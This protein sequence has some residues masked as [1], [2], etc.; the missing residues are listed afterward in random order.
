MS[1]IPAAAAQTVPQ[2]RST[3]LH[4]DLELLLAFY[5][6]QRA[7]LP[8][9][10]AHAEGVIPNPGFFT[11]ASLQRLLNN[12]LLNPD[13]I[14][15]IARAQPVPLQSACYYKIIQQK[16][17]FFMDKSVIEEHLRG[18]A[19]V[20]LEGLDILDA[21]INAF[22][23]Q[24]DAGLPCSL[25]N[26]VAFFSQA[27]NEAYRGHLDVDDVLVIHLSGEK[28]WRLFDAQAPRRFDMSELTPVQMGRQIADLVMKPGDALYVRA[29]VP[30]ICDTV[31]S[32]SL[33]LAFDLCD[34]TPQ[35]DLMLQIATEQ[36]FHACAASYTPA[37]DVLDKFATKLLSP[38]FK[39]EMSKRTESMRAEAAT[40]RTA[41]IG[42]ASRVSA[43]DRFI[44][45]SED[46]DK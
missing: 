16:K 4:P 14:G 19:S 37:P 39:G 26:S 1:A 27:G 22:A 43:L 36:Y 28:R 40:F 20:V 18:G 21:G 5:R 7:K 17:L 9:V 46:Q 45:A 34:R 41:R 3:Q 11:L 30:H 25:V 8:A 31:A 15:L 2:T 24:L 38:Q 10:Y 12:P 42:G 23:A 35:I 6:A 29:C 33:H 13:W 32:H 44:A